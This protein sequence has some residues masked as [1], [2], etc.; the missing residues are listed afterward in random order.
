MVGVRR[1]VL[2]VAVAALAGC[3]DDKPKVQPSPSATRQ[4]EAT[5]TPDPDQVVRWPRFWA[6]RDKAETGADQNLGTQLWAGFDRRAVVYNSQDVVRVLKPKTGKQI[7]RTLLDSGRYV[8]AVPPRREIE[9]GVAVFGTGALHTSGGTCDQVTG[10]STRRGRVKWRYGK[11]GRDVEHATVDVRDGEVLFGEQERLTVLDASSGRKLWSRRNRQ[12]TGRRKYASFPCKVPAALAADAPVVIVLPTD[13]GSSFRRGKIIGLDLKT[14]KTLWKVKDPRNPEFYSVYDEVPHPLDGRYLEPEDNSKARETPGMAVFVDSKTGR[15]TP[16]LEPNLASFGNLD[17][18][19]AEPCTDSGTASGLSF[20]D[21]CIF[22]AGGRVLYVVKGSVDHHPKLTIAANDLRTGKRLWVY[23][24]QSRVKNTLGY[25][26]LGV[27]AAR[28]EFWVG[29]NRMTIERIG[30]D[31]GK[32][33]GR[34]H[35]GP[36]LG[37]AR[38]A[39]IGPDFMLVRGQP[40]ITN[41]TS[42]LDYYRTAAD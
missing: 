2:L 20:D 23:R 8:C 32:R 11:T 27:N 40:G 26:V 42:G 41:V 38:F 22:I 33:V 25:D 21:T 17:A 37:L 36:P 35:P 9:S 34:G 5:A 12:L 29:D 14:G 15:T 24:T 31:T 10:I 3:G 39:S 28:T 13:C 6:T 4:A 18:H 1:I 30:L 16:Y 19:T 7:R